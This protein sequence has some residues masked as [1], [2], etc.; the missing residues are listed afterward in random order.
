MGR[1]AVFDSGLGS[2]SIIKEIQKQCK[3][4]I[5]YLADHKS[6]PYGNKTKSELEKI[7]HNTINLLNTKFNPDFVV[8]ASNTPTI[9]LNIKNKKIIGVKPPI[10]RASKLS[11]TKN[12]A[13]L[14]SK[15]LVQSRMLS[16]YIKNELPPNIVIHKI[17]ASPL[18]DL[19]ESGNFLTKK[20]YSKNFIKKYLSQKFIKNHIDVCLLSSTHLPFLKSTLEL[21]FNDIQFIDPG[22]DVAKKVCKYNKTSSKINSLKIF[23]T[24]KTNS[25]ESTLKKIGIHNKIHYL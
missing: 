4:N 7:V 17:N 22:N 21:I 13:I 3:C 23:S 24:S 11:K 25:F 18:I 16:N 10:K 12:I 1:I 20:N 2:L 15:S 6:F 19:V 8:I 14:G 9:M 5:V